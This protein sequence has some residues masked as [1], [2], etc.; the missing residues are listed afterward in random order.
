MH[1]KRNIG[2]LYVYPEKDKKKG[3]NC[4]AVEESLFNGHFVFGLHI[5]TKHINKVNAI[6]T[7]LVVVIYL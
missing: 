1:K 4:S 2:Y 5:M 3:K 6:Q 7:M